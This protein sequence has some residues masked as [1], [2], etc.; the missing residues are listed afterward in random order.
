MA[1]WNK[2]KIY[3]YNP[4][5][6]EVSRCRAKSPESCPFGAENHS[7][8]IEQLTYYADVQNQKKA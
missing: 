3:H 1:F 2:E 5:T 8:D 7:K 4:K 6:G